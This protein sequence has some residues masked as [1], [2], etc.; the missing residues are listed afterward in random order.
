M[1]ETHTKTGVRF[2][3]PMVDALKENKHGVDNP[4]IDLNIRKYLIP[5]QQQIDGLQTLDRAVIYNGDIQTLNGSII[6]I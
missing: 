2:S 4:V 5:I 1:K 3:A 6:Y